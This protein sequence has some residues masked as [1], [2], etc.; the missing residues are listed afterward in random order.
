LMYAHTLLPMRGHLMGLALTFHVSC[1]F[2][3]PIFLYKCFM[4]VLQAAV[5]VYSSRAFFRG[6]FGEHGGRLV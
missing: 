6:G 2:V 4:I 1:N 5:L 3:V